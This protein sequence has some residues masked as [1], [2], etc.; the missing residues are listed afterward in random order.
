MISSTRP[1]PNL[2]PRLLPPWSIHLAVVALAV[3]TLLLNGYHP[4]AEDGGLYVAGVQLTLNPTLFPHYTVFVSEHLHFSVFAPV[5]AF[6]VHLTHFSLAWVLLLTD[7]FSLWLTFYA[8]HRILRHAISSE[9]AR[10]AGLCLLAAFWT[11]PIAGTSL[12]LMDPYVTAR[13]LSTPLSLLAV[14]FA[15]EDRPSFHPLVWST[16]CLI[17]AAAFHPLM[18]A[19]AFAFVLVLRL[20]HLRRRYIAYAILALSALTLATILQT[21]AP[22]ETPTIIAAEKSRY[23]WFLSQWQ[24]FELLGLVGPLAVLA[25][26]LTRYRKQSDPLNAAAAALCRAC[27]AIGCIATLVALLFAHEGSRSHL[28]ARMQPLR[29]FLLIYAIMTLL[30]GATLTE[31]ALETRRRLQSQVGRTALAVLPAILILALAGTMFYVQRQTFPTSEH[32]EFPWLAQQNPNPWVQAF[33]WARD[34][35]PPD[36]LFALDTKYV[37]EDG[38][39]AQTF[40]PIALRSAVPDFS[41]DGGEAA[42]TPSL[43]TQWLQG[44]DAQTNLSTET[45]AVRD[46]RLLPLGVTWMVLHAAA[47][48]A[49][50][51]PYNNGVIKVCSLVAARP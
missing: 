14:A 42:I 33:L 34:N 23:Y 36:A 31:I 7:L 9:P 8:A 51:C 32:L 15:L 5:L 50:E 48:T 49:H 29:V 10:F 37:N 39:D 40:R 41:K 11:L 19:Y 21:I 47:P 17:L 30:L 4:L 46:A 1:D 27:I 26:L 44:A 13:S 16:L 38:E 45:D 35:T 18:A 28:V 43:A 24:W 20:S 2:S 12:L 22:T 25:A 6:L 3:L